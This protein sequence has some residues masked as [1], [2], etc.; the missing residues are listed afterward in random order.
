MT[1]FRTCA[2]LPEDQSFGSQG[3]HQAAQSSLILIPGYL[4]LSPGH[5]RSSPPPTR[6]AYTHTYTKIKRSISEMTETISYTLYVYHI[7]F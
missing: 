4:M 3:P 6:V 5:H 7:F 2:S 1:C